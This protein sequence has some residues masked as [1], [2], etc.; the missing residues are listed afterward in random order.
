MFDKATLLRDFNT[1]LNYLDK[2]L[3]EKTKHD[4]EMIKSMIE[5]LPDTHVDSYEGKRFHLRTGLHMPLL[6]S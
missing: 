5:E 1:N 3:A 6:V 4:L 2:S